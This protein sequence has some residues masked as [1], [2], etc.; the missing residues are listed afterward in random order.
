MRLF[1]C[2]LIIVFYKVHSNLK[3]DCN[4]QV[5]YYL[6]IFFFLFFLKYVIIIITNSEVCYLGKEFITKLKFILFLGYI[7]IFLNTSITIQIIQTTSSYCR[8][9]CRCPPCSSTTQSYRVST[10]DAGRPGLFSLT[11]SCPGWKSGL[12]FSGICPHLR[13]WNWP[14]R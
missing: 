14:L 4:M 10:A 1:E 6:Y 2:I 5:F 8:Q 11:R 3:A 9:E 7:L 12:K 13:E